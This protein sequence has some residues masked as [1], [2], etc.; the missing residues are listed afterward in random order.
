M[1]YKNLNRIANS[2]KRDAEEK[3]F[4]VDVLADAVARIGSSTTVTTH[5]THAATPSVIASLSQCDALFGCVDSADGRDLVNRIGTYYTIPY[6][7]VGVR[8]DANG[9][10]SIS[11]ACAAIHYLI[12]GGSSLLSRK[13]FT[14]EQVTTD[15]LHRRNPAAYAERLDRGYIHGVAVD[16]PAVVS[17]NAFAASAAVNELLA[18]LHPF[19]TDGND[20]FRYQVFSVSEGSW[21]RVPDGPRCESLARFVGRGDCVP[22]LNDPTIS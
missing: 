14:P 21:L 10:G 11:Q 20:E 6:I 8:I 5:K 22:L 19:R 18:R 15:S 12:P 16:R 9:R 2:T 1:E 4:K 7:D 17:L 3:R 13:V